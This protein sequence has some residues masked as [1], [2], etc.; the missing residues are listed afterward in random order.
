MSDSCDPVDGSSLGSSVHE[1]LQARIL[2]W[3]AI[4]FCRGVNSSGQGVDSSPGGQCPPGAPIPSPLCLWVQV[5]T[6]PMPLASPSLGWGQSRLPALACGAGLSQFLSPLQTLW[7]VSSPQITLPESSNK[8]PPTDGPLKGRVG[9]GQ[10][11]S[12]FPSSGKVLLFARG[13]RV[14]IS[15]AG[16]QSLSHI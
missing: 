5:T 15:I 3:V 8:R 11:T 16:V 1:I 9:K 7:F 10:P 6:P 4:P 13:G 2:E 12:S 14:P